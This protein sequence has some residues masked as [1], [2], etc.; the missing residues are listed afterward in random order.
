MFSPHFPSCLAGLNLIYYSLSFKETSLFHF[1]FFSPLPPTPRGP[2]L[3]HCVCINVSSKRFPPSHS[4][5]QGLISIMDGW[6]SSP[7]CARSLIGTCVSHYLNTLGSRRTF[8]MCLRALTYVCVIERGKR[9]MIDDKEGELLCVCVCE[10]VSGGWGLLFFFFF[11]FSSSMK[12]Q[13]TQRKVGSYS[14]RGARW[15]FEK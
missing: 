8:S 6:E 4:K 11:F 15:P 10:W 2:G 12:C 9:E 14:L 1:R 7:P 3:C 13:R 5:E